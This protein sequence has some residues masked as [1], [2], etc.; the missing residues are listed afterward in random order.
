MQL[1]CEA[2]LL[3]ITFLLLS[4]AAAHAAAMFG[5]VMV[6]LLHHTFLLINH[7]FQTDFLF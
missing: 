5:T 3:N 1:V 6:P 2:Q 4:S 7:L